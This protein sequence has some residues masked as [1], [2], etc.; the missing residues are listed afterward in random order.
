MSILRAIHDLGISISLDDFGTGYSSLSYLRKFPFDKIKIDQSFVSLIEESAECEAIVKSIV[1]LAK[2]LSM[3][4]TAEGIETQEQIDAMIAEG[5]SE[6]QG[7]YFS[8]PRSAEELEKL[9][10]LTREILPMVSNDGQV[11]VLRTADDEIEENL[12]AEDAHNALPFIKQSS[13]N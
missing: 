4:T 8:K 6:L 3:R 13:S 5:C 1:G 10:F 2:N 9:G 7:F 11:E 12:V